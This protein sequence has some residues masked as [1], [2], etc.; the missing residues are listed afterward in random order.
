MTD[1]TRAIGR[2]YLDRSIFGYIAV[3]NLLPEC[4][5]MTMEHDLPISV[6]AFQSNLNRLVRP[7]DA[8]SKGGPGKRHAPPVQSHLLLGNGAS[9]ACAP[10]ACA[11]S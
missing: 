9:I 8:K 11:E 3:F 7:P 2:E 1:E 5:F 10:A 4:F 6:H